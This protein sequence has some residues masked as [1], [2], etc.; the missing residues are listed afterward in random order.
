MS[1]NHTGGR[2]T[3]VLEKISQADW[4]QEGQGLNPGSIIY[5]LGDCGKLL[6]SWGLRA[7]FAYLSKMLIPG[8]SPYMILENS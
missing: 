7:L 6:T 2:T 8:L 5:W 4:S 1:L 3:E